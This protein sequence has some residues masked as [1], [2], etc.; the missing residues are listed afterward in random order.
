VTAGRITWDGNESVNAPIR[1]MQ[2]S[3]TI[4]A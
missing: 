1:M 3:A 4:E 2:V